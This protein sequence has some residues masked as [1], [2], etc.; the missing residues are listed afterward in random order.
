MK[1]KGR[2]GHDPRKLPRDVA[3]AVVSLAQGAEFEVFAMYL[4]D[5]NQL[6]T[7]HCLW[8]QE[9]VDVARG[10]AQAINAL[11]TALADAPNVARRPIKTKR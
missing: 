1:V 2:E 6:Y 8:T 4:D 9:D 10:R 7:A 3:E 11:L 5:L